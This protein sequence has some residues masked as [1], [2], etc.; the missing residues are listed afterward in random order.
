MEH[1]GQYA[2]EWG[3][4]APDFLEVGKLTITHPQSKPYSLRLDLGTPASTRS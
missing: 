4:Y 2:P 1:A 3:Q